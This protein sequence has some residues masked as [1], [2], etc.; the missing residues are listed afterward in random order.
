MK[1]YVTFA[2]SV[3]LPI[4]LVLSLRTQRVQA[5]VATVTSV[6]GRSVFLDMGSGTGVEPG[7]RVRFL[8]STGAL[9][10]ATVAA[11][12]TN[13]ARVDL[14][15]GAPMPPVGS[16]AEVQTPPQQPANENAGAA[17]SDRQPAQ[18][19]APEHPPWTR[20]IE[21]QPDDAPLLAPA[22]SRRPEQ[23][24]AEIH[25]R[26][27]SQF[28]YSG[29]D[30]GSSYTVARTGAWLEATNLF[31]RGGRLLFAGETDYRG[32]LTFSNDHQ[33][34]DLRIDRL[35]YAIGGEDYA[36][37]RLEFGRFYSANV[38]EF[39]LIDGSEATMQ[40]TGGW[41]V[42]AG[43]GLYPL[44]MPQRGWGEDFGFHLFADYHANDKDRPLEALLAFQKTWHE[45]QADRDQLLG[46]FNWRP[47]KSLWLYGLA[48][49]DIYDGTDSIKGAGLELTELWTQARYAPG[50]PFGAS[51]SFTHYNWPQL[52]RRE[53]ENLP[54]ELIRDGHVDRGDVRAWYD[55]TDAVRVSGRVDLWTDQDD[56]GRG[57]EVALD[58]NDPTG[59]WPS[60]H[61]AMFMTQGSL[62]Q[63]RGFRIEARQSIDIVNLFVGYELYQY[64]STGS[65]SGDTRTTRHAVRAGVDW[66]TGRW[67]Y[68]I[69]GDYYFGDAE[70][71]YTVGVYVAYRF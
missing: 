57:G 26:V 44:P 18:Q 36:P 67:S 20:P 34:F 69:S 29:D 54:V 3:L 58:F 55:V 32:A 60:V 5:I 12:S 45:G 35:S 1:Q 71:A 19:Q 24:S 25:G 16:K 13:N 10:E 56:S 49:V 63:G 11:V 46:R 15:P 30:Q 31:G 22:V 68:S 17:E 2:V 23:R 39:G 27:F 9:V 28:L 7:Q 66:H 53:Y 52:K 38:P 47:N 40:F 37:C 21:K 48:R 65:L 8:H 14:A 51:A 4:V 43:A 33:D 41:R 59:A 62:S 6:S 70:G 64:M 42:G 50:G 61:A